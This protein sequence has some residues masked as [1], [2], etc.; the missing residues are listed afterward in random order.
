MTILIILIIAVPIVLIVALFTSKG[1]TA[2]AAIHINKPRQQVFDYL[3]LLQNQ[4]HF[5]AWMMVDPQMKKT[6]TG[7][8][9][10]PGA[11]LAWE[12]KTKTDGKASQRIIKVT[13]SQKIEIELIFE[14]PVPSKARYWFELSPI[15]A[16]QTHVN[17]NFEGN[18]APYYWLRVS[19]MIFRLKK[20][21]RGYMEKSLAN[22]KGIL[23]Q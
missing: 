8:D 4:E 15:S 7:T 21:T 12:S 18:P 16:T 10:Q 17:W 22:L 3:V 19:H 9:G 20:R 5:N 13:P 2:Q 23:E 14:K 11:V 6:Y 1:I